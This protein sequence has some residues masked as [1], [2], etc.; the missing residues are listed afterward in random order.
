[1]A[2]SERDG[3]L[4]ASTKPDY[5]GEDGHDVVD[6]ETVMN[7]MDFALEKVNERTLWICTLFLLCSSPGTLN[8]WHILVSNFYAFV[9]PHWCQVPDLLEA[10]WTPDQI[11][12]V[13]SPRGAEGSSCSMVGWNYT[14][15][16]GLGYEEALKF[17]NSNPKPAEVP[18]T[19]FFYQEKVPH[20]S[21]VS[22]WDLVCGNQMQKS[23]VQGAIAIGKFFGGFLFGLIADRYGRKI[24]FV[25]SCVTYMLFGPLTAISPNFTFFILMRFLTGLAGSGVYETGFT[26]LA[27]I[28]SKERRANLGCIYNLS[29]PIGYLA[30]PIISLIFPEWRHLQL[31]ISLPAILLLLHCWVLP[32]SPKWLITQNRQEEAWRIIK[33]IRPSVPDLARGAEQ[34]SAPAKTHQPI[35]SR[36]IEGSH[37]LL[38]LF[39]SIEQCKRIAVA[40]F[41]WFTVALIY[42]VLALNAP[43]FN[44]NQHLFTFVS[45][46]IEIP[47]YCLPLLLFIWLGRKCTST[48][49]YFACGLALVVITTIPLSNKT[50]ILAAAMAGRFADVAVFGVI[51]VYTAELFPTTVRNTAVGSSLAISQLGSISAPYIVDNLNKFGWYVPSTI[52]GI[53]GLISAVLVLLLPETRGRPLLD[54][55]EQLRRQKEDRVSIRKCCTF[56]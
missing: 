24:S 54:T 45:G 3:G 52:C 22:E 17:V 25:L 37:K 39:S 33:R 50:I 48:I 27:E 4:S 9:P 29:Y 10:E 21:T 19:R 6:G 2:E 46:I 5:R 31:A 30:L 8:A 28:V 20:S 53:G 43:N 1:M 18:C 56:T 41:C 13:S 47:G 55:V 44:I 7:R 42:Y 51:T 36:I 23:N 16:A 35:F 49:L 40:Y 34:E 14:E 15:L 11:R 32:E 12:A 26:I 38:M